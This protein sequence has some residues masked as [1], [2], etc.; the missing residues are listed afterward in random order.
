MAFLLQARHNQDA[1]T[2]LVAVQQAI[3]VLAGMIRTAEPTVQLGVVKLLGA[4]ASR[5]A[6]ARLQVRLECTCTMHGSS[7]PSRLS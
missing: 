4:L 5:H 2:Q 3:P 6:D 1:L 7:M